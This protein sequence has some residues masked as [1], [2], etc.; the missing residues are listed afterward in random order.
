M[1]PGQTVNLS[2]KCTASGCQASTTSTSN[3]EREE[4]PLGLC[5]ETLLTRVTLMISFFH[6]TKSHEL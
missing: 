6:Y 1:K 2:V 3:G 5:Y 4:V